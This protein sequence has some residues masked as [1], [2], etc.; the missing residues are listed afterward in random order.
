M[1]WYTDL[2]KPQN[3]I[4]Y[5]EV[6]IIYRSKQS[7]TP[8]FISEESNNDKEGDLEAIIDSLLN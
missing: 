8:P 2:S 7:E 3:I 4:Q 1:S 5:E 6:P